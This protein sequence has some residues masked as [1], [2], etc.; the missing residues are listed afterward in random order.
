[1]TIDP[2]AMDEFSLITRYFDRPTRHAHV[3]LGVGDDAALL[4]G[5]PDAEWVSCVD[6]SIESRH[7]LPET[8]PYCVGYRSLAVTLSDL[9]AMGATPVASQLA[10]SMP[11]AD[12][13]WIAAFAEGYYALTDKYAMDL[14][15]GDTTQGPLV[16]TT[17]AYGVVPKGRA[18]L[19]SGACVGDDVYISGALGLAALG[20]ERI[21][22]R[23]DCPKKLRLAYQCPEPQLL[24]GQRMRD[25]AT[26]CIDISDGVFADLQHMAKASD[27]ALHVQWRE[28]PVGRP[29]KALPLTDQYRLVL[30]GGDDY[31]LAFTA[32]VQNRTAITELSQQLGV[33]CT[34]IGTVHTGVGVKIFDHNNQEIHLDGMGFR[35]FT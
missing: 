10:L 8:P 34:R 16:V 23:R 7:F 15:G 35:H 27:L 30:T 13:D 18:L 9:A 29:L 6:T 33:A 17:V 14:I 2:R 21:A 32:P 19:R 3:T 12:A 22:A 31:Q 1:M 4:A 5:V 28:I 11:R 26:A 25:L 20:L 24:L